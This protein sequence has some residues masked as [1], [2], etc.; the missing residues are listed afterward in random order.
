M[1]YVYIDIDDNFVCGH[2][3]NTECI[4]REEAMMH[5]KSGDTDYVCR[6]SSHGCSKCDQIK[7]EMFLKKV[8]E[9]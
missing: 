4:G 7:Y 2:G 6:Y 5:I 9:I 8:R 3:S 1:E